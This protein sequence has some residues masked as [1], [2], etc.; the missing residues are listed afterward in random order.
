M[1]PEESETRLTSE[2]YLPLGL[3]RAGN[4]P[5]TLI[6]KPGIFQPKTDL[7]APNMK[8]IVVTLN[9]LRVR[10]LLNLIE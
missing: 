3:C 2:C 7:S 8:H 6:G 9:L 10:R 4:I 5:S 1:H